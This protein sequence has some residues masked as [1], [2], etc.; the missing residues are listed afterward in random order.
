MIWEC[1]TLWIGTQLM[2]YLSNFKAEIQ[3][4][5]CQYL[6]RNLC[7]YLINTI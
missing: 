7:Q 2:K 6:Y 4:E 5:E 3:L 1:E